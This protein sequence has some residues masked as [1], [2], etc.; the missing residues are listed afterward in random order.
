MQSF[1]VDSSGATLLDSKLTT[2]ST[3]VVASAIS[4]VNKEDKKSY[5]KIKVSET[6]RVYPIFIK[7]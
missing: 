7:G 5:I 2:N 4:Y 1:F 3:S 6:F